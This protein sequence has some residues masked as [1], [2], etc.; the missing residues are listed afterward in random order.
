MDYIELR[1][2]SLQTDSMPVDFVF[3]Q[4]TKNLEFSNE[5]ECQ[6]VIIIYES[7]IHH[8]LMHYRLFFETINGDTQFT[9]K[10]E[11]LGDTIVLINSSQDS[12]FSSQNYESDPGQ[13]VNGD[14]II[15][16]KYGKQSYF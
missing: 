3:S 14:E 7:D 11:F 1:A 9:R 16:V 4:H 2:R 15:G 12:N 5:Q 6:I 13:N 10:P 8:T